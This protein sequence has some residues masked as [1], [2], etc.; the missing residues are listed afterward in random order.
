MTLNAEQ[1]ATKVN[2]TSRAMWHHQMIVDGARNPA[3][4]VIAALS[5]CR[6]DYHAACDAWAASYMAAADKRVTPPITPT[7]GTPAQVSV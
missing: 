2:E 6:R 3:P 7:G 5:L 4:K 1:L